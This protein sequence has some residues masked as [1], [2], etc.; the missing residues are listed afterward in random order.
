MTDAVLNRAVAR[1]VV[2]VA[3]GGPAESLTAVVTGP[4]A[5]RGPSP[6]TATAR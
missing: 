1:L 3:P 2:T 4:S 5:G 6:C